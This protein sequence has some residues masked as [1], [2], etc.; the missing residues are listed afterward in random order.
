[1]TTK[2]KT[3]N[4]L[5]K[6]RKLTIRKHGEAKSTKTHTIRFKVKLQTGHQ[7]LT[8]TKSENIVIKK[9]TRKYLHYI[10]I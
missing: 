4:R 7:S 6:D 10:N 8:M 2:I 5:H 3:G 9:S 1:M